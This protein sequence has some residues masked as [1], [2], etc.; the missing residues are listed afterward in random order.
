[1]NWR[2]NQ[3]RRRATLGPTT[4]EAHFTTLP[5]I[6]DDAKNRRCRRNWFGSSLGH[7]LILRW[8]GKNSYK[9]CV[10]PERRF[11]PGAAFEPPVTPVERQ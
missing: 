4:C 2:D 8:R 5:K 10:R 1:M 7:K 3:N 11:G 6:F 9:F